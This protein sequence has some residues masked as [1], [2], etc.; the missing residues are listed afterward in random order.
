VDILLKIDIP[1]KKLLVMAFLIM[2]RSTI[3]VV[4]QTTEIVTAKTI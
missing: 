4:L 1:V 2:V 3:V